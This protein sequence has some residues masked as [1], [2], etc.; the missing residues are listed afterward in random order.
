M[1]PSVQKAIGIFMR[2]NTLAE[3]EV[4][5]RIRG[6]RVKS[7]RKRRRDPMVRARACVKEQRRA[8]NE[9]IKI[10]NELVK[11]LKE[12]K[13]GNVKFEKPNDVL[14]L[15]IENV[16][17]LGIFSVGKAKL[18][19]LNQ[20]RYLICKY[21]IDVAA[22]VATIVDWRQVRNEESR[23]ENLFTRPGEDKVCVTA[24][25]ATNDVIETERCQKGG[26]AML[27][28]GKMTAS[29]RQVKADESGLGRFC[30][31]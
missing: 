16:N 23:F 8:H 15:I 3:K 27:T 7:N 1:H 31:T 4:V 14:R 2:E 28:R 25:N 10:V 9:A 20:M 29:V 22:F 30:W 21:D 18:R 13:R 19:K 11:E 17:S 6:L 26:T 24:H 5:R 12:D